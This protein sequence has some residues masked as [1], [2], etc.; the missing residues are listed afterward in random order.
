MM[1]DLTDDVE[2]K[3]AVYVQSVAIPTRAT[4][5]EVG[6]PAGFPMLFSRLTAAPF[7]GR[8]PVA[9]MSLPNIDPDEMDPQ[10]DSPF[11]RIVD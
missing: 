5:R 6:Q 11:L 3:K 7:P 1:L 10:K 4:F 2:L 8:F 9:S